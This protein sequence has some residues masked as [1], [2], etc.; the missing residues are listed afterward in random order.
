MRISLHVES[1]WLRLGC[2]G[3]NS[4]KC[5][6][7]G[8]NKLELFTIRSYMS[9]GLHFKG[10]ENHWTESGG[11]KPLRSLWCHRHRKTSVSIND[12][13]NG[14]HGNRDLFIILCFDR[15]QVWPGYSTCIKHTDGGLYMCVDVV[16][17][18]MRNDSVLDIMWVTDQVCC[19]VDLGYD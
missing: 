6:T 10:D 2:E 16:H 5:G 8:E 4:H 7:S 12:G 3:K 9:V 13:A 17:K 11:S 1:R 19:V 14:R 18:V 15:L